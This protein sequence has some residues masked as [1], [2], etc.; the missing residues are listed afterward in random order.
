MVISPV[1]Y[2]DFRESMVVWFLAYDRKVY[3]SYMYCRFLLTYATAEDVKG[4]KLYF[5]KL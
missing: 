1:Y 3:T 4:Y 5:K 2:V